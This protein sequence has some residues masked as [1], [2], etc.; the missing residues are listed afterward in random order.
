MKHNRLLGGTVN[1]LYTIRKLH[2]KKRGSASENPVWASYTV[3][4]ISEIEVFGY[5]A[6]GD[7]LT[8]PSCYNTNAQFP[9]YQKGYAYRIKRFNGTRAQWWEQSPYAA[10]ATNFAN[11]YNYGNANHSNAS[12]A[13]GG[14]APAFCAM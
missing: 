14:V 7:E 6:F 9:I 11:V 10:Y 1:Y 4:L 3:F 2:S 8:G 13:D 12:G 5:Q